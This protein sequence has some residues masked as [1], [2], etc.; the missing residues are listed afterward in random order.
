MVD[1][2]SLSD[3]PLENIQLKDGRTEF[4]TERY[5]EGLKKFIKQSATP[6]TIAL[7]GEWGSGKTSLMNTLNQDL[8]GVGKDFYGISVNTWEYSMLS[9]PEVAVVKI[10]GYLIKALSGNDPETNSKFKKYVKIAGNVAL[11][12]MR[13]AGKIAAGDVGQVLTEAFV[14]NGVDIDGREDNVS[15]S[16]LRIALNK[17]IAKMLKDGKRGIIVFVDDLDRL[18]PPLAVEILE[19]LKNVFTLDHCI[20]VL[21][22]DYDVVVKGLKPKYGELTEKNER[23]FRSFFDKIIQVPFSLP[24][25]NYKP[26]EFVLKSLVNVG[27]IKDIHKS[28]VRETLTKVVDS[29]VGK[30][31]RSIKRLINTLSLLD[32]IAQGNVDSEQKEDEMSLDEKLLNFIVVAIQICYPKIYRMLSQKPAFTNWD[33]EFAVKMGI[34]FRRTESDDSQGQW[35][36]IVEAACAPDPFLSQHLNDIIQLLNM[37]IEIVE[38]DRQGDKDSLGDKMRQILDKSSVTGVNSDFKPE[39][40][41]KKDLIGKLHKN[42]IDY[43]KTKRPDITDFRLKNN[44]GNGGIKMCYGEDSWFDV[45]FSPSI[46]PDNQVS[47]R[48]WLDFNIRRPERLRGKSFD[49]IMEDT[50]VQKSLSELDSVLSLLLS[51]KAWFFK[52]QGHDNNKIYFASYIDELRYMHGKGWLSEDIT[53]NPYYWV[54]LEKPSHFEEKQI[55]SAIG[56]LVI[57]NYDFRIAM[58]DWR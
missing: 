4:G 13:E 41:D 5:V 40:F 35:E 12:A 49:E 37:C 20:F 11:R 28:I 43:I 15:L 34:T 19:L 36:E 9:T 45:T 21:A 17:A 18:N 31:P 48:L 38:N 33:A 16:D 29:S 39:N 58:K 27:Y 32:C 44:T 8:C 2:T 6:I 51:E 46:N 14:G 53:N 50:T 24:V 30:N 7:Q 52:G 42:V 26:M 54:N 56:D 3:T 10:L 57:A 22:I 23:E 47:L 55:F 1:N 25:N